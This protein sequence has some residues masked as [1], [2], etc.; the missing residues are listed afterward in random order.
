ML[1]SRRG[2]LGA[3]GNAAGTLQ[4]TRQSN[5]D[6][7]RTRA[8][9]TFSSDFV[10]IQLRRDV[11]G[12]TLLHGSTSQRT[13]PRQTSNEFDLNAYA[14]IAKCYLVRSLVDTRFWN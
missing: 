9:T 13:R 14:R 12:F 8:A 7:R 1:S 6:S 2:G 3:S 5:L 4:V 10:A 11:V